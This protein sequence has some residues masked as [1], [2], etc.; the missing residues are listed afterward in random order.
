MIRGITEKIK[1]MTQ[2]IS[3]RIFSLP[4]KKAFTPYL[5]LPLFLLNLNSREKGKKEIG[6]KEK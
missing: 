3:D 4:L 2:T 6:K 1:R 5:L